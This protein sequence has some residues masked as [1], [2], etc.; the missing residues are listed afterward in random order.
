MNNL[1]KEDGEI[2]E[3]SDDDEIIST[4]TRSIKRRY[5]EDS[6]TRSSASARQR[7]E[8]WG[9]SF[10]TYQREAMASDHHY[11]VGSRGFDIERR[12]TN[13][14]DSHSR[15][16]RSGY[17]DGFGE[18]GEP[19]A[20]STQ[21]RPMRLQDAQPS[22]S[23]PV[24]NFTQNLSTSSTAKM[25]KVEVFPKGVKP[26]E[27]LQEWSFWLTNFEMATEKAGVTEQRARAIDLSLHVGEDIRKIIVMKEMLPS[28]RSVPQGFPFYD[29]VVQ[30]LEAYFH[31]LTDETVD[32]T[33]FNTMRQMEKET[34]LEYEFRLRQVAKRIKVDN[35][36]V[37]RTRFIDGLRDK[38]LKERAFV[39]GIP[40]EQVV[41]MATRKE[42]ID[43]KPQEFKPWGTEGIS[44]AAI[45]KPAQA[46]GTPTRSVQAPPGPY[47]V[48]G[49][50]DMGR[51]DRR[52]FQ[53]FKPRHALTAGASRENK[54]P[55]C[56]VIQHRLVGHCPAT[57]A[58]C[59]DCVE[60]GHFRHMCTKKEVRAI[61]EEPLTLDTNEKV[62]EMF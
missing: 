19:Q 49:R 26:T 34:A 29:N 14:S 35:I 18:L 51:N 31:S 50:R 11:Q 61:V 41:M 21:R 3:L 20:M 5:S 16:G 53:R 52:G 24:G 7:R 32:V 28:E 9:R 45:A 2:S 15:P 62:F 33:I 38:E 12:G 27:Q 47:T 42:A 37:I 57:N 46:V 17:Q 4:A 40:L 43:S 30:K 8:A 56:G 59:F 39:D 44:V 58:N 25:F 22:T 48:S 13:V 6:D 1:G 60:V 54:C 36:P 23:R 55:N 10:E